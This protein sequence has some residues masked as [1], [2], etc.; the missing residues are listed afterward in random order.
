MVDRSIKQAIMSF[1]WSLWLNCFKGNRL[2]AVWHRVIVV[3][4]FVILPSLS[5]WTVPELWLD[6]RF[7]V[8]ASL[9]LAAV[10]G[11]GVGS[12]TVTEIPFSFPIPLLCSLTLSTLRLQSAN[13]GSTAPL[14]WAGRRGNCSFLFTNSWSFL[15]TTVKISVRIKYDK[16]TQLCYYALCQ[17][18]SCAILR[19]TEFLQDS[20]VW[21]CVWSVYVF[22]LVL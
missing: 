17:L 4:I 18:Q 19:A 10:T 14:Q 2:H 11:V 13:G 20:T 21:K 8:Q 22:H 12:T 6:L 3:I 15:G 16:V 7:T 9:P 1:V 5:H